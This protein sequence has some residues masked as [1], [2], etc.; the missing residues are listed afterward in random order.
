MN[1]P[2][3]NNPQVNGTS[4]FSKASN[5]TPVSPKINEISPPIA[6]NTFAIYGSIEIQEQNFN[7]A[8]K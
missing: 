1:K 8:G 3:V 7:K 4:V 2:S 5:K 6:R